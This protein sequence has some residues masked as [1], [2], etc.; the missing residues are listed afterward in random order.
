MIVLVP[1]VCR[2]AAWLLRLRVLEADFSQDGKLA[3]GRC[4][5]RCQKPEGVRC[6]PEVMQIA[7]LSCKVLAHACLSSRNCL[8]MRWGS[9]RS[10]D[11]LVCE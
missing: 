9:F 8:E 6:F 11:L 2:P 5:V 7:C 10:R 3:P 4:A 1:S